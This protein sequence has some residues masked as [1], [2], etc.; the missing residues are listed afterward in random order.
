MKHFI[1][2]LLLSL[3]SFTTYS[4]CEVSTN[5]ELA[6]QHTFGNSYEARVYGTVDVDGVIKGEGGIGIVT[7]ISG[8]NSD[9]TFF[10]KNKF[11][12]VKQDGFSVYIVP[13][14]FYGYFGYNSTR[15]IF[16]SIEF[17][18]GF[19]NWLITLGMD[20]K[21]TNNIEQYNKQVGINLTIKRKLF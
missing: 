13:F 14:W 8:T 10:F 20:W 4:Q 9:Y 3:L 7:D 19:N 2:T 17:D 12:L 16:N 18:Y 21:W 6:L 1:L 5:V 15:D 11:R